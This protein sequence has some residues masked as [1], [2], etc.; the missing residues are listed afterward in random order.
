MVLEEI[1]GIF[2]DAFIAA[3]VFV[4]FFR[5]LHD[6]FN[7]ISDILD[8]IVYSVISKE[9]QGPVFSFLLTRTARF[10]VNRPSRNEGERVAKNC[11]ENRRL[12]PHDTD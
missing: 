11:K 8:A 6:I 1:L 4:D 3:E 9:N 10:F 2:V 12:D 5:P 7:D